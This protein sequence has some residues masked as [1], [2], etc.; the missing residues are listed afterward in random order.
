MLL[1]NICLIVYDYPMNRHIEVTITGR[2]QLVMYRDFAQRKARK[3]GIVG[4]VKNQ[5]DGSVSVVAEGEEARLNVYISLL[6]KGSV[7][8]KV[9]EV[10]VTWGKPLGTFSDFLIVY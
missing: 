9:K 5:K 1:F 2:V 7:L 6:K 3:L 8:S 4:T 10:N